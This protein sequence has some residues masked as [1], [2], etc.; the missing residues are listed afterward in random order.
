MARA[1]SEAEFILKT[2]IFGG[3]FNPIHH[4]HLIGAQET[5]EQ[6]KLDRILFIPTGTPPHKNNPTVSASLRTEMTEL[7]IAKTSGFELSKIEVKKSGNSYTI[8]TLKE[9]RHIYPDDEF[10]L[11]IGADE[12]TE[13]TDWKCWQDILDIARIAAMNRPGFSLHY[14]A[15]QLEQ[16]TVEVEIPDLAISSSELRSRRKEGC[17]IRYFVPSSVADFIEKN[18]LYLD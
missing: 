3:T 15:A 8:D 2:G 18:Q 4:G 17:S 5:L 11:L 7:A 10:Y 12:L 1:R 13:F 6:L 14:P 16:K 9:L